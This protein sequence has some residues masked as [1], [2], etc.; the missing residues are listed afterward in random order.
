MEDD[1]SDP[2]GMAY[3]GEQ[4]CPSC[5]RP[6]PV[7]AVLCPGC[8][9]DLQT[10]A[11]KRKTYEPVHRVWETG[12]SLGRRIVLFLIG[13]AVAIPLDVLAAR[14]LD[15]GNFL[16]GPWLVFSGITSFLLGTYARTELARSESGRVRISQTWRI[17]FI[18][19]PT[20]A[21]RRSK[22]E[23]VVSGKARAPD[24]WDWLVLV[25]LLV[26][27]LVPGI[28]WWYFVIRPDSYFVALARDHGFPDQTLYWGWDQQQ[29]GDMA[30]VLR[31][32][33]FGPT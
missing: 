31:E 25:I 4:P 26:S 16:I 12:W 13:Q 7:E 18:P 5:T 24:F 27:G 2:Y 32:V 21:I 14:T 9:F 11:Y 30:K 19:R 28:L 23:G 17:C 33:A 15:D 10:R 1:T 22:Y 6:I 20:R 29:A 8:G 3:T